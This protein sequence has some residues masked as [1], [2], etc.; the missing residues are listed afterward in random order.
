V[1]AVPV[2]AT[3]RGFPNQWFRLRPKPSLKGSPGVAGPFFQAASK[4]DIILIIG[5]SI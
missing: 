5:S 2:V 3:A 4:V 1:A